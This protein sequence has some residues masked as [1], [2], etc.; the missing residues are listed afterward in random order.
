MQHVTGA[1][2][3]LCGGAERPEL[4]KVTI[5]SCPMP[6]MPAGTPTVHRQ[7]GR[8]IHGCGG[9]RVGCAGVW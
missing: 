5:K 8:S 4:Y 3:L 6:H 2:A 1:L 9:V 7:T